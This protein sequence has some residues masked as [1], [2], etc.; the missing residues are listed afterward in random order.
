MFWGKVTLVRVLGKKDRKK[1]YGL[2]SNN[3][4]LKFRWQ[5]GVSVAV[6]AGLFVAGEVLHNVNLGKTSLSFWNVSCVL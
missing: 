1:K 5:A 3:V 6:H 2:V 4:R